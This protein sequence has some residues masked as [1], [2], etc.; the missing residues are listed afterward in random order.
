MDML[1]LKMLRNPEKI[2]Y[3][4]LKQR[5]TGISSLYDRALACLAYAS[6][7][8]A[9]EVNKITKQDL[10]KENIDGIEY[11]TVTVKVLKKKKTR[12]YSDAGKKVEKSKDEAGLPVL[13]RYDLIPPQPFYRRALVRMDESWLVEPILEFAEGYK[14]PKDILFPI[15][16]ATLYKKLTHALELNP[17]AFRKLRAT[18]LVQKYNYSGHQLQKFFGWSSSQPSDYYVRLNVSDLAYG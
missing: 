18:H 12:V 11:L 5:I 10:I 8:R 17:H 13:K 3:E 7:G 14:E 1:K 16:R 6:G 9:S 2:S 4:S 15:H